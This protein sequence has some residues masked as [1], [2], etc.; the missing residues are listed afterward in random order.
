M[1]S[2]K[3]SPL[4]HLNT[5][6]FFSN[7]WK[8]NCKYWLRR[9][10]KP[11]KQ[12]NWHVLIYLS[13]KLTQCI[14]QWEKCLSSIHNRSTLNSFLTYFLHGQPRL[15]RLQT[16]LFN[17]RGCASFFCRLLRCWIIIFFAKVLRVTV[18]SEWS[19]EQ[20][21][22][23]KGKKAEFSTPQLCLWG[24]PVTSLLGISFDPHRFGMSAIKHIQ[25]G[26][27]EILYFMVV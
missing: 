2:N 17:I 20:N 3:I 15:G 1:F 13:C 27:H 7:V 10:L 5:S 23:L 25:V 14:S 12:R 22:E 21:L 8:L 9:T 11:R 4:E 6:I 24:S 26:C 16:L 19:G 18:N